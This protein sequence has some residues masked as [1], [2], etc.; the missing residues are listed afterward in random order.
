MTRLL[1]LPSDCRGVSAIEY[2]LLAALI[3][4]SLVAS[5]EN[6][7]GG[8]SDSLEKA[9]KGFPDSDRGGGNGNGRGKGKGKK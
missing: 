5:L 2:A 3:A 8:L 6:L 7:G 1:R 9:E 4:L